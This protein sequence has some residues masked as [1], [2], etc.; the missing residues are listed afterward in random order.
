MGKTDT[1][2]KVNIKDQAQTF[3]DMYRTDEDDPEDFIFPF[4]DALSKRERKNPNK[5]RK[6]IGSANANLNQYLD[7]IAEDANIAED[8]SMHVARHSFAQHGVSKGLSKYKMQMLLGHS[9]V[10]TT[11]KYLKKID[12]DVINESMDIIF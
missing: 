4:C 1:E 7:D 11:E 2:I 3:L 12:V 5:L 8:I 9:S 10:K 6:K